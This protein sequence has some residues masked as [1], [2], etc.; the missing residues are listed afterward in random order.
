MAAPKTVFS[1]QDIKTYKNSAQHR[2][3]RMAYAKAAYKNK[4]NYLKWF[5]VD[6]CYF[7]K[8]K[9]G[10][11]SIVGYT[12]ENM[13]KP[14]HASKRLSYLRLSELK[15]TVSIYI[16]N[17]KDYTFEECSHEG[18]WG[19]YGNTLIT[20]IDNDFQWR[21]NT[22]ALWRVDEGDLS[23]FTNVTHVVTV[24]VG[25]QEWDDI[26]STIPPQDDYYGF[27][28]AYL[29][30]DGLFEY[31][32]GKANTR[33]QSQDLVK[34]YVI[35]DIDGSGTT[36]VDY[37][38]YTDAGLNTL[39]ES[40]IVEVHKAAT[41]YIFYN[42]DVRGSYYLPSTI[43]LDTQAPSGTHTLQT[44]DT[45]ASGSS[46]A[47][48][49][50]R[51]EF[52]GSVSLTANTAPYNFALN[53]SNSEGVY[54]G[55]HW[56]PYRIYGPCKL[57]NVYAV[58]DISQN[59]T[60]GTQYGVLVFTEDYANK[61]S[62]PKTLYNLFA[63]NSGVTNTTGIYLM[64]TDE[65]D[66]TIGGCHWGAWLPQGMYYGFPTTYNGTDKKIVQI[67]ASKR[68]YRWY[69]STYTPA[70]TSYDIMIEADFSFS[71]YVYYD[72]ESQVTLTGNGTIATSTFG[73][74]FGASSW[75]I[76]DVPASK[77][78]LIGEQTCSLTIDLSGWGVIGRNDVTLTLSDDNGHETSI[79]SS[80]GYFENSITLDL[81]KL[82]NYASGNKI[83]I[84]ISMDAVGE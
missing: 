12:Y 18:L 19:N 46:A 68:P 62:N 44:V 77:L 60:T 82:K 67:N 29:T 78:N 83:H 25:S 4:A 42:G 79:T 23:A 53:A 24:S 28:V 45:I 72:D 39:P 49:T 47:S 84:T 14:T 63:T 43:S 3:A 50:R 13:R 80:M 65:S 48:V 54:N 55:Q 30:D 5:D 59:P 26:I 1:K 33:R 74:W 7:T 70:V 21:G 61:S 38:V 27:V 17:H 8:D 66:M 37:Q 10:K 20:L 40:E 16:E 32:D 9:E 57:L 64:Y 36:C 41:N 35:S 52:Q 71:S 75:D 31:N 6:G 81:G 73:A 69:N 11:D 56:E 51:Q 22:Y 15:N 34:G 76:Q 58:N 2:V